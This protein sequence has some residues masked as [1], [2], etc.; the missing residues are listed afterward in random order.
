MHDRPI[1][2]ISVGYR[3]VFSLLF[4]MAH[5]CIVGLNNRHE[6]TTSLLLIL[7]NSLK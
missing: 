1:W 6:E 4:H 2:Y 3:E 5:S 7:N